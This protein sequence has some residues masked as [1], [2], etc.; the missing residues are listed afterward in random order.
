[1]AD[2]ASRLAANI[3]EAQDFTPSD[4][5]GSGADSE[6]DPTSRTE[7]FDEARA[8]QSGANPF[9]AGDSSGT[10]DL[11]GEKSQDRQPISGAVAAGGVAGEP[12]SRG[13]SEEKEALNA[14]KSTGGN[15]GDDA[16]LATAATTSEGLKREANLNSIFSSEA[17]D[18]G[19]TSAPTT[20]NPIGSPSEPGPSGNVPENNY[21]SHK[22]DSGGDI[23]EEVAVSERD[24]KLLEA[25][26]SGSATDIRNWL[27]KGADVLARNQEGETVL[28]IVLGR[29]DLEDNDVQIDLFLE[30]YKKKGLSINVED[31]EG[32]TLLYAAVNRANAFGPATLV[33]KIL[34]VPGVDLGVKQKTGKTALYQAC[35]FGNLEVV[36]LILEA[37]GGVAHLE[38][39]NDQGWTPFQ[40]ACSEGE[41]DVVELLLPSDPLSSSYRAAISTKDLVGRTPLH[42]A[43]LGGKDAAV[44]AAGK[45]SAV[46]KRLLSTQRSLINETDWSSQTALHLAA[47]AGSTV[48]VEA[49]LTPYDGIEK[50]I[51]L[52]VVDRDGRTPLHLAASE[53]HADVVTKLL[54]IPSTSI[55]QLDSK[56]QTALHLAAKVGA[57]DVVEKLLKEHKENAERIDLNVVDRDGRTALHLAVQRL[58]EQ[59]LALDLE[60][61]RELVG[62]KAKID[63]ADFEGRTALQLVGRSEKDT[64]QK[65]IRIISGASKEPGKR[66]ELF[67]GVIANEER[68]T[69]RAR[70][71]KNLEREGFTSWEKHHIEKET[72][73]IG[74]MIPSQ[75]TTQAAILKKSQEVHEKLKGSLPKD[76]D[77]K[78]SSALQLA[79][80]FGYAHLVYVLLVYSSSSWRQFKEDCNS[81]LEIAR[82]ASD[83]VSD[84]ARDTTSGNYMRS[85][86]RDPQPESEKTD[87][88]QERSRRKRDYEHVKDLFHRSERGDRVDFL[89]RTRSVLDVVYPESKSTPQ[90][91]KALAKGTGAGKENKKIEDKKQP[92]V[93]SE[94]EPNCGAVKIMAAARKEYGEANRSTKA[95]AETLYTEENLQFRWIHLSGNDFRWM[96]DLTKRVIREGKKTTARAEFRQLAGFLRQSVHERPGLKPC[97]LPSCIKDH[98]T[99]TP[100]PAPAS[101]TSRTPQDWSKLALYV[102]RISKSGF[103][104]LICAKMPY[105]TFAY[106]PTTDTDTEPEP[107]L[108]KQT[109]DDKVW[110]IPH[111]SRTLDEFYYHSVNDIETRNKDQVVTRYIDTS[112]MST[113]EIPTGNIAILR[114]DHIWIW[115]IDQMLEGIYSH[116]KEAKGKEKGQ[117]PPTSVDDMSKLVTTFCIEQ[118]DIDRIGEMELSARQIFANTISKKAVEDF[119]LFGKFRTKIG[120]KVERLRVPE[121]K[122]SKK[123]DADQ[124]KE[125]IQ[126]YE[127]I[128]EATDLLHEVKDIRD[129]LNILNYLLT[130]QQ[131]VWEKLL[132]LSVNEYGGITWND[133][134]RKETK[135]WKGPG[136]ALKDI[137]EMDKVAQSIQDSVN[138]VL[139]LEQNEANLSEAETSRELSRQTKIQGD[140]LMVFTIITIV[141]VQS[142]HEEGTKVLMTRIVTVSGVIALP[143]IDY[144]NKKWLLRGIKHLCGQDQHEKKEDKPTPTSTNS[145]D[146]QS[147]RGRFWR[148]LSPASSCCFGDEEKGQPHEG[149]FSIQQAAGE[150]RE[151]GRPGWV[152]YR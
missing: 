101:Q 132:D 135:R 27:E 82:K 42:V 75:K 70:L 41:K 146:C 2:Q 93:D 15:R 137:I 54:S 143:V 19:G 9:Q 36:K 121:K 20:S 88:T 11:A 78:N 44:K 133:L 39:T 109:Q 102:G 66:K 49:L 124:R 105:V 151:K 12:V 58:A 31:G 21:S 85:P 67:L 139:A 13:P 94:E 62:A 129:E 38:T 83:G 115:V 65:A 142:R 73:L 26:K 56:S 29:E 47:K 40:V 147:G 114:V 32:R 60:I 100:K 86:S 43:S 76:S 106:H 123:T 120:T 104:R 63:V 81:A 113:P 122:L 71:L 52:N 10:K 98:M 130:Q 110:N 8:P 90:G 7:P 97:M 74:M 33:S 61:V 95:K 152:A 128:R 18:D 87:E 25:A 46:I 96:M 23:D 35:Y 108:P 4:S 6:M 50:Q 127:A 72:E 150:L 107:E 53:G 68:E 112:N 37:K 140:T 22:I 80:Y 125:Q 144:A 89:R 99:R 14:T 57:L 91:S 118:I 148:S 16:I 145:T 5:L 119:N 69:A 30:I 48:A 34:D 126:D 117:P 3:E 103:H 55:N 79:A 1:M 51:D 131:T 136:L 138:S 111:E 64:C 17:N 24:Q 77:M 134:S 149:R 116:L 59:D 141:F 84:K 45:R 92:E 28:Y